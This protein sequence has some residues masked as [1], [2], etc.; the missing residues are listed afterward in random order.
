MELVMRKYWCLGVTKDI[1]KYVNRY[2]ICQRMKN[3]IKTLVGNLMANKVL[4][5]LWTYLTVDFI[6]K[7]LLV[8]VSE[9]FREKLAK[10]EVSFSEGETL[11]EE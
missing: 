5:K 11:K 9:E 8:K 6:T 2:N 7:L 10:I 1:E 4:E 3:Q